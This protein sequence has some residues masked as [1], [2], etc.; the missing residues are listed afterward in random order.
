MKVKRGDMKIRSAIPTLFALLMLSPLA[1]TQEPPPALGA[2]YDLSKR[3]P[4]TAHRYYFFESS[5]EML[6]ISA[7]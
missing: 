7:S 4:P 2:R 6:Y 1:A 3:L 5:N